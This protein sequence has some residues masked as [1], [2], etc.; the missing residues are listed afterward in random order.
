MHLT[1]KCDNAKI[2]YELFKSTKDTEE[3]VIL[4]HGLGMDSRYWYKIVPQLRENFNVITFDLRGHG[5][6][7]AGESEINW[8]VIN[9]D[10]ITLLNQFDISSCHFIGHGLGGNIAIQFCYQYPNFFK[11]LTIISTLIYFPP[12]AASA[13]LSYRKHL[14]NLCGFQALAEELVPKILYNSSLVYEK[15]LLFSSYLK[16]S[17]SSLYMQFFKTMI[18]NPHN[19][20][21]LSTITIPILVIDGAYDPILPKKVT[22]LST[23]TFQNSHYV[24]ISDTADA[25]FLENP[26]ETLQ[27]IERFLLSIEVTQV[28]YDTYVESYLNE[29]KKNLGEL[30]QKEKYEINSQVLHVQLMNTFSVRN[31]NEYILEGWNQRMAKQLF[32]YL[33]FHRTSTREQICD[34]LMKDTD[35]TSSKKNL[36]VYLHYLKRLINNEKEEFIKSDKE[37]IYLKGKVE[38][39]LV[40]YIN[41]INSLENKDITMFYGE[42]TQVINNIPKSFFPSI[43]D[44][45]ALNLTHEIQKKL[46]KISEKLSQYH[47]H[48]NELLKATEYLE[49]VMEFDCIEVYFYEKLKQLYIQLNNFN[50]LEKLEKQY[51]DHF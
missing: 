17:S 22:G 26:V 15:D 29:F 18:S 27:V 23:F 35:L 49:L 51:S 20:G 8:E 41:R 32:C 13:T 46:I 2:Y 9:N 39:D 42:Y 6:S 10:L 5:D 45:W 3:Y 16:I 38:C 31:D 21:E 47:I 12:E 7:T 11:T 30:M 1:L 19:L 33:I 28:T 14:V 25:P 24:T 40:T 44:E 34:D 50:K 48:R 36:R 4:I 37:H 43:Y